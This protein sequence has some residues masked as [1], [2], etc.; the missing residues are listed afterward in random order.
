MTINGPVLLEEFSGRAKE[1][2]MKRPFDSF[3]SVLAIS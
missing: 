1:N 3:A 2:G